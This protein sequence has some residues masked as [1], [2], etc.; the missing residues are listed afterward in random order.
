LTAV[1]ILTVGFL[2]LV[3]ER[4]SMVRITFFLVVLSVSIWLFCFSWMYLS[5]TPEVARWWAKAAHIGIPMIAPAIH[6]FTVAVLGIYGRYRRLVWV[7]WFVSIFFALMAVTTGVLFDTVHKDWWGYYPSYDWETV[8]FVAFFFAMLVTSLWHY[9]VEYRKAQPGTHKRRIRLLGLAFAIGYLGTIDFIPA[10]G[11]PF[12]P[13][14]YIP[15]FAFTLL[16]ARVV[17]SYRLVDFTPAF[18]AQ[19]IIDTMTEGLLVFDPGGVIRLVNQAARDLFGRPREQL[20]DR[21]VAEVLG[22]DPFS[23]NL[24]QLLE[25]A[26]LRNYEIT[27]TTPRGVSRALSLSASV[28]HGRGGVPVAVVCVARDITDRKQAEEQIRQQ[29]EYLAALHQ[30]SLGLMNRLELPDLLEA[31]MLRAASLVGTSHGYVYVVEAGGNEM[32]V[33][34]GVGIFHD[35]IGF[36]IA[37][38]EGLAGRVWETGEAMTVDDYSAW[39]GRAQSLDYMS[40]HA[41]AGVPLKSGTEVVGVLGLAY[42]QAGRTFG[43]D[44]IEILRRF[45]QLASIA[46]DNARLY[47]AAQLELAERT[48]A[49]EEIR[50]LNE[51]LERR[52]ADRTAQLEDAVTARQALLSIVSHDLGNPLSI[53][54][55]SSKMMQKRLQQTPVD[56]AILERNLNRIDTAVARMNLLINDLTDFARLQ[57]EQRL[58]LDLRAVDLVGLANRVVG[59]H[60]QTT[61]R[62]R[63][64]VEAEGSSQLVGLW[65][66]ARLERVLENLLSN[67]IKYSPHGGDIVVTLGRETTPAGAGAVE[68]A[69]AAAAGRQNGTLDNCK[70]GSCD[71]A[72]LRVQDAGIGIPEAD[73]P[74]IF[75]WF[76]RAENTSGRIKGT[77]IGLASARLI[78]EQHGGTL[79]VASNEGAGSTFTV[80]LPLGA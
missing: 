45:A 57:A 46:L 73:L 42:D 39:T 58:D 69:R 3:R 55:A 24:D 32:V 7:S 4:I 43:P 61:D 49:E 60:Q 29:K 15:I 20:V 63:I 78:V 71:W 27:Y 53:I 48:L 56:T 26:P 25:S 17:W 8:P 6:Q 9:S 38:G 21:P 68:P 31:I 67:A 75:E 52:V 2:V 65:D 59:E 64:R 37:H 72:T 66:V 70:N 54:T 10:Y 77:G 47:S 11:V 28:M 33:Q 5:R 22:D 1:A 18:A 40:L 36:R 74:H 30:T 76:H 79:T 34:A 23:W 51:E 16:A 62:H 41:V 80:R 13:V 14:G 35:N 12:Y 50:Q 44:E 19:E